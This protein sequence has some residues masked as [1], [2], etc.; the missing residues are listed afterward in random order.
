MPSKQIAGRIRLVVAVLQH[1]LELQVH[2]AADWH[3]HLLDV[4]CSPAALGQT[5]LALQ[6]DALV[7]MAEAGKGFVEGVPVAV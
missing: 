5:T 3:L 4:C 2:F 1:C 6:L 7:L